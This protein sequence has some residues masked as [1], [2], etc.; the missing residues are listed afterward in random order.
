MEINNK[1]TKNKFSRDGNIPDIIVCH[2]TAG[3]NINSAIN[4]FMNPD[5]FTSANFLVGM[6]GKIIECVP[7]TEAAW[8]NGNKIKNNEA[9]A[10]NYYKNSLNSIVR[11][12]KINA[13]KYTNSIE[14]VH[15][16]DG[17]ITE[18]QKA[19]G[20][21]LMNY[22]RSELKRIYGYD[23]I[24]DRL[25]I[26]GHCEISPINKAGC[27]GKL[28]PFRYFIDGLNKKDNVNIIDD[29]ETD[30][31]KNKISK[32]TQI[33]NVKVPH[34]VLSDDPEPAPKPNAFRN[35]RLN[36]DTVRLNRAKGIK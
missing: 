30:K 32:I 10:S 16:G 28:F 27:P 3:T 1:P 33:A 15:Q 8:C 22:I 23:F 26:I 21:W 24:V 12:R 25:H 6:D 14:F 35:E 31:L 13:N 20:L 34:P 29:S 9:S 4:W 18:A 2:Q 5:S 7:I 19:S 11:S 36:S 17:N